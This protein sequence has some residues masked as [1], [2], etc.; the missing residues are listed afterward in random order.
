MLAELCL[1]KGKNE[2]GVFSAFASMASFLTKCERS[3]RGLKILRAF[4]PA[5]AVERPENWVMDFG[6]TP[7]GATATQLGKTS[8]PRFLIDSLAIV[9]GSSGG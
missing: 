3:F 5:N 4:T 8:I 7:I 6:S 1:A 2:K 9:S